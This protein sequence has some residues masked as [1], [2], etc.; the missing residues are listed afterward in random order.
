MKLNKSNVDAISLCDSGQKIYRDQELIGFAVRA[1]TKSKSYIVERRH[2]GKLYRVVLGKTNE[3]SAIAARAKAQMI[4]AQIANEEYQKPVK[5]KA[6]ENPLDITVGQALDIYIKRNDFKPKTIRQYN[7]YFDLYLGWSNRK[8]FEITKN[9][10]LDKFL[11]V[12]E[13]SKSSANGAISLLGTLWKYIHVLYSSDEAPIL[14]SNPVDI[15]SVTKGWN[16]LER[17]E[18]HLH[19]DVIH[20]YYNAVLNYQDEL[21][22]ENTARSNTH[23]DIILF[24]MY[25]GCRRQEVCG[26]KWSDINFKTGTV[27]FRDTKNGTDHLFPVGD[28]LLKILKDRYLL[29]ENDWVFPATKMPTA[30]NMHATK[31][32]RALKVLGDQVDYYVSMHDFRRTFATICNLLRFNI[33][34]T[35]R[36]LNHT[37]K[38]RIDVTGGYVQI[39]MEELKA[40]MNMIEAVYQGKIDCFNYESVW[41]ERL[42][43]IKA[44]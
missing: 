22:L 24:T 29:R 13:L 42:K 28:H 44:G 39:P 14:K 18:R 36:L 30:A 19:K 25:T 21:N 16:T 3:I 37:Q 9:E 10:V 31:V 32:D 2:A 12:S 6:A 41:D 17:R 4:L 1:T 33:Y 27:L 38:P 11:T 35:K 34:V 7:K 15:I 23:R 26:L 5:G 8:L 43:Q 20:K 40:S